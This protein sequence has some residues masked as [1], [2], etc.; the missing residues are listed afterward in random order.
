MH[1]RRRMEL[2]RTFEDVLSWSP[3]QLMRLNKIIIHNSGTTNPVAFQ[4]VQDLQERFFCNS[5][6]ALGAY[7]LFE[8]QTRKTLRRQLRNAAASGF[9]SLNQLFGTLH[10][11]LLRVHNQPGQVARGV[12]AQQRALLLMAR[13]L[14]RGRPQPSAPTYIDD[15]LANAGGAQAPEDAEQAAQEQQLRA[16]KLLRRQQRTRQLA[17]TREAEAAAVAQ[18]YLAMAATEPN[19][20]PSPGPQEAV[21]L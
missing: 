2:P 3:E 15:Q 6:S 14:V 17:E 19:M 7:G 1:C 8:P 16:E 4:D 13:V 5:R 20:P 21:I 9:I 11:K 18:R 12:L 10:S